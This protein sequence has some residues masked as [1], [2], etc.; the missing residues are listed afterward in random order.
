MKVNVINVHKRTCLNVGDV[1][2]YDTRYYIIVE[3]I[4]KDKP[5]RLMNLSSCVILDVGYESLQDL[6][7]VYGPDIFP[8]VTVYRARNVNI[9]IE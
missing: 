4:G 7:G 1:I 5:F 2:F 9:D 3:V 6:A 8:T